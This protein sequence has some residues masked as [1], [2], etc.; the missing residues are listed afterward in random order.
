M[1]KK[2]LK[3]TEESI[4]TALVNLYQDEYT[5]IVFYSG[6]RFIV[7]HRDDHEYETSYDTL[8]R[9]RCKC[10]ICSNLHKKT[11]EEFQEE[12]DRLFP[13]KYRVIGEYEGSSKPLLIEWTACKHSYPVLPLSIL[14]GAK[15]PRCTGKDKKDTA[16]FIWEVENLVGNEY[17]VI[18]EY[19][20]TH[21]P[22]IIKHNI[23]E[24]KFPVLRKDFINGQRCPVCSKKNAKRTRWNTDSFTKKVQELVGNEYV[25]QSPYVNSK[26][27]I[28]FFHKTC[29]RTSPILPSKFLSG[30]R[31]RHCF[32]SF[33]ITHEGFLQKVKELVGNEYIVLS[34]YQSMHKP[35]KME[36]VACGRKYSVE[37]NNFI[38]SN[39]RCPECFGSEKK[40]TDIFKSQLYNLVG[41]EYEVLGEY[42]N[43]DTHI[44]MKHQP[45]GSIYPVTP[46]NFLRGRR[47]SLCQG[48]APKTTEMFREE[49]FD[50]VGDEYVV[51]GNYVDAD[52]H[53]KMQHT[54]CKYIYD[55]VPNSFLSGARCPDCR[56]YKGQ[57]KIV[58][59]I[60]VR[61]LPYT[62]EYRIPGNLRLD[63][64][65]FDP[66]HHGKLLAVIE[67]QGEQHYHPVS[68]YGGREK[69][70]R[71][72]K[73]DQQKRIYCMQNHIH[74]IIIPYWEFEQIGKII[75][76]HI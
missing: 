31:C 47:C 58:D 64:A 73:N 11:L 19:V 41:E 30:D 67:F 7:R 34:N 49:V 36:H 21:I 15:C 37:P 65:V 40:T 38:R 8:I 23:C 54:S 71:Q 33:R 17:T 20:N 52:T 57:R 68:F 24:T 74:L 35:V 3:H 18:G 14:K 5:L 60:K 27:H 13:K 50:L 39:T 45:C 51:L 25:I 59:H 2:R 43:T 69:F 62:V 28:D 26:N 22:M 46:N 4:K 16:R 12:L 1:K 72:I 42:L 61:N 66:K 44:E 9:K 63:V 48:K 56:E 10:K 70:R 29:G 55:V 53:I 75:D 76:K 32:G 6:S